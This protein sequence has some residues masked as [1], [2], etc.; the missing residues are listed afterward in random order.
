MIV[1]LNGPPGAGKSTI[2]GVLSER[3]FNMRVINLAQP[4]IDFTNDVLLE[5]RSPGYDHKDKE[6]APGHRTLRDTYIEVANLY[7]RQ[8]PRVWIEYA[9]RGFN[10][11]STQNVVIDSIGKK[12][13]FEYLVEKAHRLE[14][15]NLVLIKV[16]DHDYRKWGSS[17]SE[18]SDHR[19]RMMGS[20]RDKLKIITID[21][22][23]KEHRTGTS[24]EEFKE[25][26]KNRVAFE[27]TGGSMSGT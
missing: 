7:E 11:E 4:F 2:A 24:L 15:S 14:E 19:H 22:I 21:N 26:I 13:Q 1:A 23:V 5:G 18:F 6:V 16:D 12:Q 17:F 3:P 20:D 27:L 9:M 25:Y 8:N 10:F